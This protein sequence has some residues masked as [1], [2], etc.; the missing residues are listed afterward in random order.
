VCVCVFVFVC[1]C[2][3]V[4]ARARALC[5]RV[6]WLCVCVCVCVRVGCVRLRCVGGCVGRG[7][8]SARGR[9][10]CGGAGHDGLAW[11]GPR[12]V[13]VCAAPH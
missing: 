3:C 2:V 11:R 8:A 7:L 5:K 9:Q 4:C 1:V 10:E 12:Y 13:Y 6:R